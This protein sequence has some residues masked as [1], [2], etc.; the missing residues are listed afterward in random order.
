MRWI[1][2]FFIIIFN[3]PLSA[4]E[5]KSIKIYQKTTQ[6]E[7]LSPSDW[8]RCD[9]I[10]NTIIWQQANT[11]NLKNN[12]SKEYESIV[13]RRDFYEWLY[14]EAE[15]K[16][17]EVIWIK[18]AH[19][20]SKKMQL[21]EV[22]PYSIFL[23]KKTKTYAKLGSKTVFNNA[24]NE[25][26]KLYQSKVILKSEE[27]IAWD[28]SIL[29][30]EQYVWI[31]SIYKAMDTK[32]LKNLERIAKGKFLYGLIVPKQIRFKGELSHA[33]ARYNYA[34]EV[35]KPYCKNRYKS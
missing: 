22:F 19:F 2:F 21:M 3:N 10:K 12:L 15:K 14:K 31:D 9:R 26:Q 8:L 33:K 18:M 4:K 11:Y 27:A 32:S 23:K 20:I 17:Y 34:I 5:W 30:E 25:L 1:L 28:K 7:I 29:K 24:F 35:L 16:G 13:Q 6:K